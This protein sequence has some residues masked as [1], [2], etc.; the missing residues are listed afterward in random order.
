MLVS[1]SVGI[2]WVFDVEYSPLVVPQSQEIVTH[3]PSNIST[4][5]YRFHTGILD[6]K[7]LIPSEVEQR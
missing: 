5:T 7:G 6:P 4:K 1:Q 2:V 3:L